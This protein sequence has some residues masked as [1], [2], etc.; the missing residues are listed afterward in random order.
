[1]FRR[2]RN[3]RKHWLTNTK[4]VVRYEKPWY[5]RLLVLV[6]A[7][8][9]GIVIA[10]LFRVAVVENSFRSVIDPVMAEKLDE[11]QASMANG[12]ILNDKITQAQLDK[13]TENINRL[14]TENSQLKSDLAVYE[15]LSKA[16]ARPGEAS[17][18][19]L[20]ITQTSPGNYQY[21][22]LIAYSPEQ[23]GLGQGDEFEGVLFLSA[24][25]AGSQKTIVIAGQGG[26]M[27]SAIDLKIRYFQRLT[28]TFRL[29]PETK[30]QLFRARIRRDGR[31]IDT[32]TEDIPPSFYQ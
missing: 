12:K 27:S 32:K 5:I 11:C 10:G 18:K 7:F 16:S 17:I 9:A 6:A 23:R 22:I 3:L 2:V 31:V 4:A 24:D 13:L 21:Q 8:V 25:L 20:S 26:L 30:L 28:G 1:M 15:S 14:Q 19:E 29:P